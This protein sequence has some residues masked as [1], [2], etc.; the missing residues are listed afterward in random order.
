MIRIKRV[1]DPPEPGD[2]IRFLV[3]RLWPRGVRKESLTMEAWLKEAGPSDAL[4][5]L[6]AGTTRQNG[7]NSG[8]AIL[9]NSMAGGKSCGP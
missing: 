7:R 6:V 9:P 4:R 3:E 2:G 8:N 5:A 1:Y